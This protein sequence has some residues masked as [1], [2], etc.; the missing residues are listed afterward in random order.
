MVLSIH[1]SPLPVVLNICPLL[2]ELLL[3][4]NSKD[5]TNRLAVYTGGFFAIIFYPI[6][7]T[8]SILISGIL[9]G[10]LSTYLYYKK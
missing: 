5:R 7:G 10:S 9:G 4:V 2:P 8:W 6:A 1:D 3:V